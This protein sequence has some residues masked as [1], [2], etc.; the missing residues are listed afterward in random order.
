VYYR[1]VRVGLVM[2]SVLSPTAQEVHVF[3]NIEEPYT[4][5]IHENTVFWNA[6]GISVDAGIFR[7]LQIYTESMESILGGGIAFAT[8]EGKE[9]GVP[10]GTGHHF[11]LQDKMDEDWLDWK[12]EIK[13]AGQ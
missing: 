8:P 13:L 10:A 9:M 4:A 7:G 1:Q 3:V 11:I 12:P 6:S 2:G 5:L